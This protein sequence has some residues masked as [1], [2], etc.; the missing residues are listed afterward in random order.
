MDRN[1][2]L[3]IVDVQNDFCPG[4]ALAVTDGDQVVGNLN[5]YLA[6]FRAAAL[7][8]FVTR[9]WHPVKTSH[10]KDFGGLWPVHCVQGTFGAQF[11]PALDLDSQVVILSKGMAADAD[12]YSGF[13]AVDAAGAALADLLKRSQTK[14]IFIGGLTTDYCVKQ[15][16]IDGLKQGFDMVVLKDSIRAVELTP[17]DSERAIEEMVQA[18]AE[19]IETLR[20]PA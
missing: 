2:A 19:V 6:R 8:I 17:G 10:F 20:D 11:H 4:G 3:V 16:V 9:D 12:S 18:G 7:P 5:Q 15:T 1:C 13:D 14:R